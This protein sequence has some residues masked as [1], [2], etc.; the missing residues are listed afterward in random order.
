MIQD[1]VFHL[2]DRK[3]GS[4]SIQQ[5]LNQQLWSSPSKTLFFTATD[6]NGPLA[7]A[8]VAMD[9]A[10][11]AARRFAGLNQRLGKADADVAVVSSETFE[12]V[13]PK[14]LKAALEAYLP[15]YVDAVRLIAYVRPHGGRVLSGYSEQ[16]KRGQSLGSLEE[17]FA[18][19]AVL[20]RFTSFER[21][22]RWKEVFGDAFTLRPMIRSSLQGACVVQ[23]FL[24]YALQSFDF[25]LN[26]DPN[27][28]PSLSLDDLDL[29]HQFHARAEENG[30]TPARASFLGAAI[31]DQL[32]Q[33][34]QSG[35]ARATLQP[36]I[37]R[38]LVALCRADAEQLD[39]MFFEG[40]PM[41]TALLALPDQGA[42]ANTTPLDPGAA[43]VMGLLTDWLV[44]V[45]KQQD[46]DA[47]Q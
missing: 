3:T 36:A 39:A 20:E 2:G 7:A 47:R 41:T 21:F 33:R 18:E 25:N 43:R 35:A 31:G 27:A 15:D 34:P 10:D 40:A 23:D 42:M 26:W 22:A 44:T 38:E 45:G 14:A 46:T 5:T 19:G 13:S 16:I 32:S 4:T 8:L 12:D 6:H 28:N 24:S 1:L 9:N 29:L 17:Y 11:N 37:A 30:V